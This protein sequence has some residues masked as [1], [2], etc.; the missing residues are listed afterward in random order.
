MPRMSTRPFENIIIDKR[1]HS[2]AEFA[3]KW[4]FLH[5]VTIEV[6]H[7][8]HQSASAVS[9]DVA[10]RFQREPSGQ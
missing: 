5:R 9:P 8:E 2:A 7:S 3:S 10:A 6:E 1:N 4:D